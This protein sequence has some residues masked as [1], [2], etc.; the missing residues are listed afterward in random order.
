MEAIILAGGRGTRLGALTEAMPKPMLPVNG[1]PFLSFL[2][3][4][5][6][7]QGVGRI[8]LS[9]G[10]R[11]GEVQ[12]YFGSRYRNTRLDYVIEQEPLGTGGGARLA[13]QSANSEPV[14]LLNGDT[15]FAVPLS[16][17][18]A[19]REREAADVVMALRHV[20][21]GGRYGSVVES[22]GRIVGFLE[23]ATRAE[24]IINGGVYLFGRR[25]LLNAFPEGPGS[26]ELDMFPSL[27]KTHRVVG[28]HSSAI[29]IDIGLPAD[30]ERAQTLL[31]DGTTA[32]SGV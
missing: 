17:M 18:I 32:G 16:E 22:G 27:L 23:K 5:L 7:G 19:T 14:F 12:A 2:L 24:A 6:A 9:V 1:R 21:D 15:L 3:D 11:H 25:D 29:F 4:S 13:L 28:V 30:Y 31:R 26:L 10:Y 8:L 20:R